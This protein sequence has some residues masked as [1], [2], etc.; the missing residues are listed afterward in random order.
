LPRTVKNSQE[1]TLFEL[2]MAASVHT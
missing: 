1:I 2:S